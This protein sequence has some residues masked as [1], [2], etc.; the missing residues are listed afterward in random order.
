MIEAIDAGSIRFL[1]HET[2][3]GLIPLIW[4][5]GRLDN[6]RSYMESMNKALKH[7]AENRQY[8]LPVSWRNAV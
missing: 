8:R 2:L 1:Q 4:R 7:V 5:S 6:R 3:S